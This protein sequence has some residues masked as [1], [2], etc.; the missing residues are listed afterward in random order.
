M[1]YCN[2]HNTVYSGAKCPDCVGK[3]PDPDDAAV[4]SRDE[5]STGSADGTDTDS[6]LGETIADAVDGVSGD[7][8]DGDIV[9]GDQQKTVE[10]SNEIRVDNSE[11][12][13]DESEER[14][15]ESTTIE[16][17]TLNR[18]A[19]DAGGPTSTDDTDA[20]AMDVTDDTER[21][22][23]RH[24]RGED[25]RERTDEQIHREYDNRPTESRGRDSRRDSPESVEDAPSATREES[26]L[27]CPNCGENASVDHTFCKHC[28]TSIQD[29]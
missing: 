24:R 4:Q 7:S 19:V 21:E 12:D 2:D 29:S 15:D 28:G 13:I 6:N 17:S 27:R 5:T 8:S 1:G 3:I 14:H 16:D 10:S 25:R 26:S 20:R 11:T 18:T 9:L 22:G 23:V